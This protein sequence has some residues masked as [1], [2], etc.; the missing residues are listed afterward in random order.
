MATTPAI[1]RVKMF[2]T[3]LKRSAS[4]VHCYGSTLL[5]VLSALHAARE[6]TAAHV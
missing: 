2:S 3:A 5:I 4:S 6:Q 1:V